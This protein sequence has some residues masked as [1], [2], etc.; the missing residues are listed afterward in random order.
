MLV[1]RGKTRTHCCHTCPPMTTPALVPSLHEESFCLSNINPRKAF[2]PDGVLGWVLKDCAAE[3]AEIFTT[4][5]NL[6]LSKSWVPACFKADTIIPVPKKANVTCMNDYRPVALTPIPAKCL[7]RLVMKHIQKALPPALD[8][9]QF[10][11][12]ESR[13]AEDAIAIV[14]HIILKHLEHKNTYARLLFIDFGSA[15]NT[16]RPNT[17]LLKLSNLGLNKVLCNWILDFLTNHSQYV[18]TG[19]HI[20]NTI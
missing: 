1:L 7:E 18:K 10:A 11:Y 2:G 15:F 13:S 8:Q 9:Y 20:S 16:I 4:I 6:L 3:L 14:L 12:R 5:F 17:L 19:K